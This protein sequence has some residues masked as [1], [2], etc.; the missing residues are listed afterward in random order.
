MR[1]AGR[2]LV[3]R[4]PVELDLSDATKVRLAGD[5]VTA[6]GK[7]TDPW[8]AID[9]G[10]FLLTPAVFDALK[11]RAG[12]RAAHRFRGDADARRAARALA[13]G[14][15]RG[16]RWMDVDTPADRAAAERLLAPQS[17]GAIG[18]APRL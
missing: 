12:I 7:A 4:A 13:A 6:I 9:A 18:G 2:V 16:V 8:D 11:Q 3:D 10:C 5:R 14:E 15:L 17:A 1:T